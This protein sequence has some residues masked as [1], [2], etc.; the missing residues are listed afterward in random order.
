M[1]SGALQPF[2][3]RALTSVR[4]RT[5][6][7]QEVG[8]GIARLVLGCRACLSRY[9]LQRGFI[10]HHDTCSRLCANTKAMRFGL[11]RILHRWLIQVI[12]TIFRAE[13]RCRADTL[14]CE[15]CVLV[16][17]TERRA[18]SP[19]AKRSMLSST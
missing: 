7:V 15:D 5:L 12:L 1:R 4:L 10:R 17:E 3:F 6:P 2:D 16:L 14:E 9:V 19:R 18:H 11:Q 8:R 13:T